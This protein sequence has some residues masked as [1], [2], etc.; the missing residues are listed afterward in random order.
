MRR[1]LNARNPAWWLATI[2][3]AALVVIALLA[4]LLPLSY[5][6]DTTDLAAI[7]EPPLTGAHW[8]GTDPLGRDLLAGLL[9]GARTA[10]FISIPATALATLLGAMVGSAAGFW[11]NGGLRLPLSY[12]GAAL[13]TLAF[14]IGF[15][16]PAGT[17]LLAAAAVA[18]SLTAAAALLG[19]FGFARTIGVPV[20]RIL[21]GLIAL[22]AS[23]PLLILALTLAALYP[24]SLPGLLV[25][26]ILTYWPGPA[27]LVRAEV[28]RIR[29]LP[30]AEAAQG[31][32]VPTA[33]LLWRHILPNCWPTISA[34]FPLSVAALIGLE[35]TLSFLGIGLPPETASWGRLLASA[36]LAPT[37]WWLILGP[38][39]AIVLT[40][41]ALRQLSTRREAR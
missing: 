24:P 1:L 37:A 12:S 28:L 8:L 11:S 41:L 16:A 5:P 23:V 30:Y 34:T 2:W 13:G 32:G 31:L 38:M 6:P 26:L 25:V 3:L 9:F 27:R 19:R 7:A 35:T 40:T 22:L 17:M 15:Q 29:A 10:L 14:V 36:R 33:R 18:L 21:L 4:P 20:D 39:L